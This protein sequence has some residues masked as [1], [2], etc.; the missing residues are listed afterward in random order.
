M[1][2]N[3]SNQSATPSEAEA[4]KATE[5]GVVSGSRFSLFCVVSCTFA[6]IIS[7]ANGN[8][9]ACCAWFL[10][11]AM[12]ICSEQNKKLTARAIAL[13]REANA[14]LGIS[15]ER[16]KRLLAQLA[17]RFANTQSSATPKQ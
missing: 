2:N 10:C 12:M 8:Y 7:S 16:N 5:L 4:V 3:D 9:S 13:A 1:D 14:S 6:A 17:K 11:A 15:C